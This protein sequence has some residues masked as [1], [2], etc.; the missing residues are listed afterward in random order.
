MGGPA[1]LTEQS[2]FQFTT[3][4]MLVLF[5]MGFAL[6]YWYHRTLKSAW[7]LSLSY[8]FGSLGLLL[9][10]FR[11]SFPAD[12]AVYITNIP[13]TICILLFV[14][15]IAACY[16]RPF[17]TR[18]ATM[19]V[20][21][22][23][24]LLSWY[25]FVDTDILMRTYAANTTA[26]L[27]V[28]YCAVIAYRNSRR[29]LDRVILALL[30]LS[31]F[32]FVSRTAI[33][34][35]FWNATTTA[36]SYSASPYALSFHLSIAFVSL[37]LAVALFVAMG[38]DIISRVERR[39]ETDGLTGLL[40]RQGFEERAHDR[41]LE[42]YDCSLPL[43]LIVCDIDH[44]KRIN[45]TYGHATGDVVI[46]RFAR[47]IRNASRKSDFA[48]RI[49]GEEFCLLLPTADTQLGKLLAQ[50]IRTNFEAETFSQL[51]KQER[52]TA[53]FGVAELRHGESYEEL[54]IRADAAL[55]KAK[56]NGRNRVEFA[57]ER[58]QHRQNDTAFEQNAFEQAHS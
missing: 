27:L 32:Q 40:N 37:S 55:Y 10:I 14:A 41:T 43:T 25:T 52:L 53:S 28:A 44:F 33:V 50:S 1:Q 18:I 47:T 5:A 21:T 51:K 16:D 24:G 49:G 36:E 11:N 26:G 12:L 3:P 56:E 48:G 39:A 57:D 4:M 17:P 30:V 8:G 9:D 45:D 13:F 31:A 34:D 29:Q 20:L 42:A 15:G 6:T 38:M 22:E 54:F 58:Q 19:A 7:Y 46:K 2:L 23:F 35:Y